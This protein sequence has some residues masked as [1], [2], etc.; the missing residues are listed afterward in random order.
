MCNSF[1]SQ[2]KVKNIETITNV[3]QRGYAFVTFYTRNLIPFSIVSGII[4]T[5]VPYLHI[6]GNWEQIEEVTV[7]LLMLITKN[8]MKF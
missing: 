5:R 7:F 4:D 3:H 1:S 8:L 2:S 6:C